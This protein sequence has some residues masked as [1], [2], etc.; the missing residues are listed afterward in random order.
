VTITLEDVPERIP[1]V[2]LAGTILIPP[3]WGR[4]RPRLSVEALDSPDDDL[5][6]RLDRVAVTAVD[7]EP[8][9]YRWSAREVTP[10]RYALTVRELTYTQVVVVGPEGE[11]NARIEIGEPA[12][13]TVR[14][15]D[16]DTGADAGIEALLWHCANPEGVDGSTLN[17]VD[18]DPAGGF[19]FKAPSGELNVG[20]RSDEYL[21]PL[22]IVKAV[23]G[24]NA[25]TLRAQRACGVRLLLK[26]GGAIVP[27][28]YSRHRV[29]LRQE[30]GSGEEM[31]SSSDGK[32][33]RA[34][35]SEPGTYSVSF[36]PIDGYEPVPPQDVE[37]KPRQFTD[38]MITLVPAR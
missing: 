16:A 7:G 3:A 19:H 6:E 13:I 28:D 25:I 21:L 34:F 33:Y 20:V 18:R 32:E 1:P 14:V 4:L 22:E 10:G 26:E 12:D 37:V 2:P 11:T 30:D 35:V 5:E 27:W 8:G 36:D 9:L 38:V 15:V 24:H 31:G 17:S 29:H 23:P